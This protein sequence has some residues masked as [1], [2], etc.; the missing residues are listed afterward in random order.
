MRDLLVVVPSHHRPRNID[1]LWQAMADTCRG[2]TH[3]LVGVDSD[4]PTLSQYPEGP[5]YESWLGVHQVVAWVNVL[6]PPRAG[7]YR[8]I[9]M[10]GDDNLPRTPGWD[11]RIMDALEH[12]EFAFANDLYPYY[13]PLHCANHVF[14]HGRVIEALGYFG[15]PPIR[16]M[17]IDVAWT[18]WGEATSMAYLGDVLIEHLHYTLGKA[19][20]DASY[21]FTTGLIPED[22]RNWHT[23]S[24]GGQLNADILKL[25]GK[26]FTPETLRKFNADLNIPES[27]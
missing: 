14:T 17:Y 26:P 19:E 2:D 13:T 3:L 10:I 24:R 23:Y 27:R 8:Y 4:D 25:G 16:H 1:R 9:G 15:P 22:L 21:A 11:L 7:Q 5:E 12:A 20:A 18:A 6:A